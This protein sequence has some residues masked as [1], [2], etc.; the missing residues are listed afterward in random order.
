ME[1]GETPSYSASHKGSKLGTT[2]LN[3]AKNYEVKT[4]SQFTATAT[5]SHRNW[6][7]RQF[8]TDQYCENAVFSSFQSHQQTAQHKLQYKTREYEYHGKIHGYGGF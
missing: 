7:F 4:K 6:K 8:N 2:F 1:P 5:A 3:I